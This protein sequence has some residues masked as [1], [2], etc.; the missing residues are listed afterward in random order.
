MFNSRHKDALSAFESDNQFD[1]I[2]K[3]LSNFRVD[4]TKKAQS[5]AQHFSWIEEERR[6]KQSEAATTKQLSNSICKL[7]AELEKE[8]CPKAIDILAVKKDLETLETSAS[9]SLSL[10]V[11]DVKDTISAILSIDVTGEDAGLCAQLILDLKNNLTTVEAELDDQYSLLATEVK[12]CRR[13]VMQLVAEDVENLNSC[14]VKEVFIPEGLATAISHVRLLENKLVQLSDENGSE[15]RVDMLELELK[16]ELATAKDEFHQE[17]KQLSKEKTDLASRRYAKRLHLIE[18]NAMKAIKNL[19][20]NLEI[21]HKCT[22]ERRKMK[23]KTNELR[24]RIQ[25]HRIEHDKATKAALVHSE[26]GRKTADA[27]NRELKLLE[28]SISAKRT[29][30][31]HKASSSTMQAPTPSKR[32]IESVTARISQHRENKQRTKSRELQRQSKITAKEDAEIAS[33]KAEERRLDRLCALA[34]SVPYYKNIMNAVPDIYKTTEARK[35]DVYR[36]RDASLAD[37]QCG[38][39]QLKSFTNDKLFS[40]AKFRLANALH[41]A[42]VAQSIYARNVVR[43]AIPRVEERTTGIKP[44]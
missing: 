11:I 19:S 16:C 26:E 1:D 37:F 18:E 42:G 12:V 39:A 23:L 34:A 22:I 4:Q 40:D 5:S 30:W 6:L 41:E 35:N 15:G 29:I 2:R 17:M 38:L 24:L 20:H 43:E 21:L 36:G 31:N 33:A 9:A 32:E 13:K 8:K 10:L 14:D 28:R 25:A 27:T 7:L 44:Y 3:K